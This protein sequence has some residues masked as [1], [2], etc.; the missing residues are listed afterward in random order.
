V[1]GQN[2][3]STS[4][5]NDFLRGF[6]GERMIDELSRCDLATVFEKLD[7]TSAQVKARISGYFR[8]LG[9]QL[10]APLIGDMNFV[11]RAD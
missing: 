1:G 7:E 6:V 3:Y 8:R 11:S 4:D 10:I 2:A 5:V 9:I